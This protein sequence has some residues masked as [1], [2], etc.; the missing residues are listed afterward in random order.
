MASGMPSRRSVLVYA[1]ADAVAEATGARLLLAASDA[2][3]LR[4]VAHIVLTGGTVGIELLRRAAGS[5]LATTVDW[6][7]VH[8][9]W[10][11]ERFVT[12]GD[13]DRNEG[14]AQSA[15]LGHVPLPEENIHRVG[16]ADTFGSVA[17][18]AADYGKLI[19][20]F[21][22]PQWDV[23]LFGMGPDGH[24][25]S[26]FPGLVAVPQ[27]PPSFNTSLPRTIAVAHS[28]KPPPLRVS[29]TFSTINNARQV[30]VV[31]AGAEKAL[32][33]AGA[34][35]GDAGIPAGAVRGTDATLWLIDAAAS[36][37]I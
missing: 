10:G 8:L 15:L 19:E 7:S 31:A 5:Q 4:G 25:A 24:V 33:V 37:R 30:W 18:A 17:D 9:W 16:S 34:L 35:R 13:A 14:Q 27:E 11:D 3:A 23:A 1:D 12:T 6:T 20:D 36:V 32:A 28:P 29:M 26:L 2:I 21:G 22:D